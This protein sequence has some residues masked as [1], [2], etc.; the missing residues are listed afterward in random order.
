[1]KPGYKQT[2]VGVIPE[3]WEV[4]LVRE[5]VANSTRR[6][7]AKGRSES[8]CEA[9]WNASERNETQAALGVSFGVN[10][11]LLE[12]H[13]TLNTTPLWVCKV[14]ELRGIKPLT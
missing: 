2:E 4:S 1:M 6:P 9:R 13:K 8:E 12:N 7:P 14:V 3:D 10:R 5:A 11:P